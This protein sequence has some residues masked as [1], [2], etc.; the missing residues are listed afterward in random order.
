MAL[1]EDQEAGFAVLRPEFCYS[2]T[3][4]T[5]ICEEQTW[6]RELETHQVVDLMTNHILAAADIAQRESPEIKMRKL[7]DYKNERDKLFATCVPA[8]R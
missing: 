6:G 4:D 8:L 3:L 2:A 1:K 5:C 7:N